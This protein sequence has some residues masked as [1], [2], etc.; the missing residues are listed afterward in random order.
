MKPSTFLP[1]LLFLIPVVFTAQEVKY[2]D[3][4]HFTLGGQ[5]SPASGTYQRFAS[6]DM[7]GLPQRVQELSQNSAGIYLDFH[8]DSPNI[9]LRWEVDQYRSLK[10]LTSIAINGFD[11][12][13]KNGETWQFVGVAV[14]QDKHSSVSILKNGDGQ[15]RQYR[16][17]FPLYTGLVNLEIGINPDSNLLQERETEASKKILIYGSSITQGASASRP[18]MA[19]PSL[20][21]RML[22]VE[23]LNFG[24]SGSGKM[25]AEVAEVLSTI[26]SD[27]IV[28]DCVPNPSPQEISQRTVPFVKRLRQSQ[29]ATPIVMVESVFREHAHWNMQLAQQVAAQNRAFKE[30]YQELK[31]EG[32]EQLY[33]VTS[34]G[35][36][37][38][39]H[40]GTIDGTHF[41]DLGHF[42]MAEKLAPILSDILNDESFQP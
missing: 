14:P 18:G 35:H 23:V 26:P 11:L 32:M 27:L 20:L 16:L 34:E 36:I 3:V 24:F 7:E 6:Q 9:N 38:S 19:F 37:G 25:E 2:Y 29:P 13:A 21:S 22:N 33:Y 40:E 42:R 12:Y 10:N 17:H 41:S 1:L 28:L 39:D 30:A 15:M 8:T 4:Q 31:A 5:A